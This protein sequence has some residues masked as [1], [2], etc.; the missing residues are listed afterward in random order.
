[1]KFIVLVIAVLALVYLVRASL[2]RMQ[3]PLESKRTKSDETGEPQQMLSCAQCG[4]HLPRDEALPGRGGV[5]CGAQ[6]RAAFE[7]AHPTP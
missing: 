7:A 5:F 1:M 6:H 3:S 4:I 2:R